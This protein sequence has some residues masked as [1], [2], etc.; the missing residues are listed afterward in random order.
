MSVGASRGRG[1]DPAVQMPSEGATRGWP[2][3]SLQSV[4]RTQHMFREGAWVSESEVLISPLGLESFPVLCL[5]I[6]FFLDS[7]GYKGV[8]NVASVML[9]PFSDLKGWGD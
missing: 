8:G 5:F 7:V 6:C 1:H 2:Q 9:V 3:S 4:P